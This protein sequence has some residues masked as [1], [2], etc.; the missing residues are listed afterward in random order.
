MSGLHG[1]DDYDN[2][3]GVHIV[4][5][6]QT[7]EVYIVMMMMMMMITEVSTLY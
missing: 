2:D 1:D 5:D 3:R 7:W 6:Q 4:L